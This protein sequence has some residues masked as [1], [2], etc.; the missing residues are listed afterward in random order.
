MDVKNKPLLSSAA[1]PPKALEWSK[2]K[3]DYFHTFRWKILSIAVVA[4]LGFLL[5]L[6]FTLN[7]VI[8]NTHHLSLVGEQA[9]PVMRDLQNA[10]FELRLTK[11]ALQ[12]AAITGDY[13]LIKNAKDHAEYFRQYLRSLS[14]VDETKSRML[15]EEFNTYYR[16]SETLAVDMS[17]NFDFD[18]SESRLRGESSTKM[19]E[20]L[21]NKLEQYNTDKSSYFK[22]ELSEAI[23][24]SE[25]MLS[26]GLMGGLTMMVIIFAIAFLT[27]RSI[28][29]RLNH[30]L[31]SLKKLAIDSSDMSAKIDVQGTDEMAEL[32]H[33]FNAFVSRLNFLTMKSNQQIHRMA[34]SDALT[35][36][37]NR[38]EFVRCLEGELERIKEN[39]DKTLAVFFMDLD[40]FKSVNDQKGHDAGD[41]LIRD[42]ASSLQ[43]VIRSYDVLGHAGSLASQS[44]DTQSNHERGIVARM[45]GDEFILLLSNLD[46]V[47]DVKKVAS[48]ILE[49]VA[50]VHVIQ[51][52][53]FLIGVSIGIALYRGDELDTE[54][55][56]NRADKA[57]YQAKNN[58]KNTFVFYENKAA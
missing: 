53:E 12:E 43:S 49:K 54:D 38:R 19:Y 7:V 39:E 47:D 21:V 42:V 36:L 25:N 8:K 52:T 30:F 1:I 18:I 41:T 10:T 22:S 5:Y 28:H 14:R 37:P 45:G 32:A 23:N 55:L 40:N 48:R 26:I 31:E 24:R 33:W 9:M 20:S 50:K 6:G 58:G 17:Q 34:F 2:R 16:F 44:S 13:D 15:F 27:I 35:Q 57:M 4:A 51:G 11:N 3:A 29:N 46:N 56:I